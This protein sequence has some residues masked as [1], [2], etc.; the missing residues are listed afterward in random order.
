MSSLGPE[1][2][3]NQEEELA[4][5]AET[6][7]PV[8]E[9]AV[10]TEDADEAGD[11][12]DPVR[13]YLRGMVSIALLTR[14]GEV[15][16]ARR[17]EDAEHRVLKAVL[18]APVAVNEILDL[19]NQLRKAKIRVTEVTRDADDQDPDFD[20]AWHTERV[21][22]A[23]DNIGRVF[24]KHQKLLESA[25]KRPTAAVKARFDQKVATSADELFQ[26]LLD[27]RLGKERVGPILDQL[28]SYVQRLDGCRRQINDCESRAGMSLSELRKTVRQVR[29][30]PVRRQALT[31]KLG[32]RVEELEKILEQSVELGRQL[33]QIESDAGMEEVMLRETVQ[34]I[35]DGEHAGEKAKAEMIRANLRLV[36]AIA[37]KYANRG[38]LFLDL[39]QE[40]NIGLMRAVEKFE[41][42]R[43][44]KF[45]TYAT[46]WIRQSV[47]RAIADQARTIRIP[48]HMIE[49]INKMNRISRQILQETG[50]EPD[51][52]TLAVKMEMPEEK[53]R[54]ILKISKEPIS[55]ET[56]IGDDDD[57]HLGDF[58]EDQAGLAPS[59]SAL[60]ASLRE[61]TKDV[62][63]SLTPREAK[64]LRMR[65]GIEMNTDHTLEEVG[66]QFDVTRE[67]IRQI[68]AKALRKL[69]HPSR[70]EKLRS[71][72]E[73]ES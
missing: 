45:S 23:L 38:L 34:E 20:E 2:D 6:A 59:D 68:E 50:Q 65:F 40:G 35:A 26:A 27:I 32:L 1:L 54:K 58:I 4:A 67:R 13:M 41:Y 3:E 61:A 39:I 5:P 33:R 70:S 73:G 14:E 43:G 71:F 15:A 7:P 52:A 44:Y 63:D 48:V 22:K 55:M 42:Q 72:L 62:L 36:V 49:T 57:S 21:C 11:A 17:I 24:R 66:K 30:S 8:P 51:P 69:R 47:S 9:V 46:W 25:P 31:R 53:I 64:V 37:K 10:A 29:A 16:L 28:K 18:R 60:Y 56:P 12:H 19:G